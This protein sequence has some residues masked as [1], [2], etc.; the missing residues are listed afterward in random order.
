VSQLKPGEIEAII[1]QF[2]SGDLATLEVRIGDNELFLSRYPGE[3]PSWA[4][5]DAIAQTAAAA[6][7]SSQTAQ[8]ANA[9]PAAPADITTPPGHV[10]VP[11]P[12]MGTFYR[13]EK[14][15]AP[16]FVEVGDT[17]TEDSELCLIEVMKLFTSVRAGVHGKVTRILVADATPI[18]LGQP[19]FVVDTNA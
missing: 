9:T 7:P 10:I 2:E 5:Q 4:G 18:R 6:P 19:L 16:P 15:D 13:A 11:A 12:C 3:R 14:P 8:P 1:R 17:V